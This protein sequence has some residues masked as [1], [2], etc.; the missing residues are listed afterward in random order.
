MGPA[1]TR[2]FDLPIEIWDDLLRKA[3]GDRLTRE[4]AAVIALRHCV[5][6]HGTI[7]RVPERLI[8]RG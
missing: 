6:E 4:D 8:G 5:A 2:T 7:E 1:M 3:D